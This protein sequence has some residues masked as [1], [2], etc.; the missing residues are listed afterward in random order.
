MTFDF[1]TFHRRAVETPSHEDVEPMRELL[2]ETLE[3]AGASP[4]VDDAGNVLAIRGPG[5]SALSASGEKEPDEDGPHVVLNTHVDTVPTHIPYERDGDVVRGRGACD[6]K[7]PLAALV[8]AFLAVEPERGTVTLAITPDEETF[9][10]GADHLVGTLDADAYI[11]GEPTE[12]DV[13][14]AARGQFEGDVLLTGR[15]AHAAE[16]ESGVNAI[17][18]AAPVLEAM[19]T[20][21]ADRG[22]DEHPLLGGST[23]TAT[24]IEGGEA[25]NQVPEACRIGF[26][27]RSIP[28]ETAVEFREGFEAYLRERVPKNVGVAVE[29]AGTDAPFLDA[30]VTSEEEPLVRTLAAASG[31][32]VRPF[33]A[34][35]E[36][37]LFAAD[38]PTVV[39]GPGALVD[40]EGPVAHAD[41][42]YVRLSEIAAAEEAVAETLRALV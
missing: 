35:T 30:F 42:E 3:D 25:T 29:L 28:P 15:A 31:G 27:R 2:V 1:E 40:D 18:A 11:V 34:A 22:R 32:A 38:A 20:F 24:T 5:A 21:D 4:R 14:V 39:F 33:T 19:A 17:A 16:P 8:G 41:R 36:A 37:S 6:A 13:C 26:D 7:G 10:T 23:L 9:Q 12:L